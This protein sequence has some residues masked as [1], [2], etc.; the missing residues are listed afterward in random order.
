MFLHKDNDDD[1]YE[2]IKKL[3]LD[4]LYEKKKEQDLQKMVTFNKILYRVHEKIKLTSRQKNGIPFC[5]F[6]VPEVMLGVVHYDHVMCIS[7]IIS[8]LEDN[9]FIVRY[10]HPNLLLI[11]WAHY[12]PT[13]VRNE[14]KKQT[15]IRIDMHGNKVSDDEHNSSNNN[16]DH[17]HNDHTHHDTN[18]AL[19]IGNKKI[20]PPK[21]DY[22][23]ITS[24]MPTGN[25]IYN[26]D[27]LKRIEEK[28]N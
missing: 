22:K 14:F 17:N 27:Y 19:F 16:N 23:P 24:Y 20:I 11:S 28:F 13:Y 9:D 7:Y 25:L 8:K 12:I 15:G 26:Q 18:H 3:N 10:T 5:W 1:D 6:I 4:D 21:K 2:N